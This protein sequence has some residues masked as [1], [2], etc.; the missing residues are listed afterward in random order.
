MITKTLVTKSFLLLI[1]LLSATAASAETLYIIDQLF[2][3]LRTGQSTEHQ[4][5]RTLA[6]GT[7]LERLEVS[8]DYSQVRT[9][10]GTEG[11][12]LSQYL[13]DTPIAR[14]QLNAARKQAEELG[15]ENTRLKRRLD[16]LSGKEGKLS[17]SYKTL[18]REHNK[19]T[20]ELE[21]LRRVTAVPL[22]LEAEN[23]QLKKELVELENEYEL[24]R[25]EHQILTDSSDRDWFIT[26]AGAV[27][28]GL[29]IGLLAP[30]LRSRK[31]SSW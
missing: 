24:L 21:R 23:Q 29:L 1:L 8:G 11:W 22:Q 17:E 4:V 9:E 20:S 5:V 7:K 6:S 14:D 3:T 28:L 2:V 19:V 18:E 16:E 12:V 10:D 31:K 26:G 27:V 30:S 13:S 15:V 25:Q